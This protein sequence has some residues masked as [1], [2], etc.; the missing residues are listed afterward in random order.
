LAAVLPILLLFLFVSLSRRFDAAILPLFVQ[1]LNN[2]QLAGAA[3][4]LGQ[5]T[6]ICSVAIAASSVLCGWLIDRFRP[7]WIAAVSAA[8]GG[9]FAMAQFWAPSILAL[10]II[11][12]G[13]ALCIG[14]LE[15]A[16]QVWLTQATD[17]ERRG[18]VIGLSVSA[19]SIGWIVA[20]LSS[21]FL[22]TRIGLRPVFLLG[23]ILLI[24][25][26]PVILVTKWAAS[27]ESETGAVV[28]RD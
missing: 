11:R 24:L 21:S 25:L 26:L 15:P 27:P 7:R 1:E 8:L 6:A 14:G 22:A 16:C 4:Q 19:R 2:H 23:G 10:A 28:S 20:A 5:L 12:T 18:R 9:L 3:T 13:A 17:K